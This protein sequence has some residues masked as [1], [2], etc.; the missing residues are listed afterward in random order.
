MYL[1][2]PLAKKCAEVDVLGTIKERIAYTKTEIRLHK[3][4]II[5]K[6][7]KQQ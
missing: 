5:I 6:L 2:F 4:N 1:R 7:K 3:F